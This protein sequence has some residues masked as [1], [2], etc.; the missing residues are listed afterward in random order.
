MGYPMDGVQFTPLKIITDTRGSVRHAIK[1][2]DA[3]F[4]GFGEAYFSG[5]EYS[6]TKGW[7]KHLRMHSNIIPVT[8]AFRFV[9]YDDREDSGT[10]GATEV[11]LLSLENYGRLTIP[12]GIWFAF[13]GLSTTGNLLLNVSS[14]VHDP[15]EAIGRPLDHG[16]M[17]SIDWNIRA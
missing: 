15:S 13:Q 3:E 2:I 17:P 10:H 11:Y 16:E 6:V 9:L 5:T 1:S 8:G 7:K 4:A 14:I 12:P